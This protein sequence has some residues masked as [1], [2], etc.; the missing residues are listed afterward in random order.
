MENRLVQIKELLIAGGPR[1]AAEVVMSY[2]EEE[3]REMLHVILEYLDWQF[4]LDRLYKAERFGKSVESFDQMNFE[5]EFLTPQEFNPS[6]NLEEQ[7]DDRRSKPR[8]RKHGPNKKDLA[9]NS[10]LPVVVVEL[11]P[12]SKDCPNC[13]LPMEII[14]YEEETWI[15]HTRAEYYKKVLRRPIYACTKCTDDSGRPIQVKNES[16]PALIEGSP[17]TPELV[18]SIAHQTYDLGVPLYRQEKSYSNIGL[19]LTRQTMTNWL[20]AVYDQYLYSLV[21]MMKD[22]FEQMDYV[23]LDETTLQAV[24][25]RKERFT[26]YELV[27]CSG[28]SEPIQ[29]AFFQY[30]R[31]RSQEI[32]KAM[33]GDEFVGT[34]QTDGYQVYHNHE[35]EFPDDV[36]IIGCWAHAQIK[37]K[38][39]LTADMGYARRNKLPPSERKAWRKKHPHFNNFLTLRDLIRQLLK[40]EEQLTESGAD[41]AKIQKTR[42]EKSLKLVDQIFALAKMLEGVFPNKSKKTVAITYL[43]NQEKYLRRCLDGPRYEISNLR[44]ERLVKRLILWRKNSLFTFSENGAKRMSGFMSL[45]VTAAMNRLNPEAYLS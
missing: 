13:G 16:D 35:D 43:T 10:N 24:E 3:R 37:I 5:E 6:E 27:G 7:E 22:D 11:A 40:V 2:D 14:G 1:H 32:V 18:A 36:T 8:K 33:L 31:T 30:S 19:Y 42:E 41:Y 26:D 45:L 15:C 20:D 29:M 25:N 44:V 28:R 9:K 4:Q 17:A 23:H 39:A 38:E 12:D 34:G 21:E